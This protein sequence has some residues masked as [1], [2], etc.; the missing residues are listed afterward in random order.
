MTSPI[1]IRREYLKTEQRAPLCPR[2]LGPL[3]DAGLDIV[4]KPSVQRI[5]TDDEYA[6]AGATINADLEGCQLI[7]GLKEL[8]A[9]RLMENK[10]HAF[11][12]H[13][14]KGQPKNMPMLHHLME[15][16]CTLIDHEK[17]TDEAG[18]RLVFFGHH[19]GLAGM[20]DTLWALG[21]RLAV[22]E[23]LQTPLRRLKTAFHYSSYTEAIADVRQVGAELAEMNLPA[24]LSPLV[25]GVAGTGNASRGAQEVLCE[26]GAKRLDPDDLTELAFGPGL[27]QVIFSE[28]HMV[29]PRLGIFDPA[30]F[31]LQHYYDRPGRYRGVFER[32]LPYLNVL[33]N[34]I[35][36]DERY[37][38]LVTLEGLRQLY[39]SDTPA[40]LDVIGDISCDLHGAIE[41]TVRTTKPSD[42]V[43]VYDL[44]TGS[45][46]LGVEG[47]GPVI[48][49]IYNLPS[50][51]PREASRA[52]GD[53]LLPFVEPM[54][55]AD[56][57]V[58]F[59]RCN[60]PP[61]LKRATIVYRGEL[62]PA[63]DYL[64]DHLEDRLSSAD[65]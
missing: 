53:A 50:E 28:Q 6:A 56:Y 1:A 58:P 3:F 8:P 24:R 15:R 59:D 21:Q 11:F 29:R 4:V 20:I 33:V 46:R 18:R 51:F 52:F 62:T 36:W 16:G 48:L 12:S 55:R 54:A 13:T 35:Y 47:H 14:I 61:P 23:G 25:F 19:A 27:Y 49:A 9:D 60:L 30:T 22:A 17:I 43:Y 57:S 44:E 39:N 42:P 31:D 37:P 63:F 7:L 38:R 26:L 5:F 34:C 64:A 10:V 45:A 65:E 32:Y 41:A 40:R 2:H